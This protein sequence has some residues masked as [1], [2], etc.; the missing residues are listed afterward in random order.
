MAICIPV[1]LPDRSYNILIEKGSLANLGAE[2]SRLSLGKKVLLVSNPEIFEYYGQI[3]VNSLEKAGFTVSTHLIPAGEN[4]KTLDSIA[5]VYDSALAHRLER[6][7]TMVALGGGVIGD[8]TGFAAATWL[9]GVNFVQVP[10][11]LL[12]MVDASIGGKTGV[13]HPQGKN[14]IGAF[15]QPKLVLIDPSVL[16]SLPVREFRAGMAEVIKYGVIWD[17]ELFKQ[18]EDSDNLASFSQ[19]DGELLQTIITKSCQAKADVV[20]KDEK[21][22]GLRAILNYGH[23]IA[24]GIESLTGYTKINHGEA[25]A[26]G[27]VAAGAIAVK[28][29]MWT[30][31]ENQRQ[32]ALIAKSGLETQ[33]PPLNPDQMIET[34]TADKKVK[35]GKVRFIL[36]TAIGQVTIS[37]RVTPSMVREVL[38]PTKS[39]Q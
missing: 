31:A 10:T 18:L 32:T 21:E 35:D 4:Y 34:L 22:A 23:T 12:A 13:N 3:A 16:K 6:S 11:T 20:I 8:M 37:D 33:I 26:M 15:Y 39:G 27:M 5:E 29:G 19:I 38:P 28:L 1:N 30:E 17:A 9:R 14:L 36:P 25:V 7:S 2:M 24:H